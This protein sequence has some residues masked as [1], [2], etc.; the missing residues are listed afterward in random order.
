M[1]AILFDYDGVIAD[2]MQDNFLAWRSVLNNYGVLLTPNDYFHLE[3]TPLFDLALR[4]C[5]QFGIEEKEAYSIMKSKDDYFLVHHKT[6]LYPHVQEILNKLHKKRI[7]LA[8]VTAAEYHRLR[9]SV[10]HFVID[11]FKVVITP[12]DVH[13][14]KPHPASYLAAARRLYVPITQCIVVE[15]APL[16]IEAAKRAGA[17]CIA[18]TTTLPRKDLQRA[19]VVIDHFSDLLTL[20]IMRPLL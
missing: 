1:K 6:T 18:I 11:K 3:G 13:R 2:T 17:Y 8:L 14:G 4:F 10:P 19:D 16:G 7:P 9:Q 15:N 5:H 20:P 12:K